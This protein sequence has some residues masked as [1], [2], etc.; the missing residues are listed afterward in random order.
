MH[1]L[2]IVF[3]II[4]IIK[5]TAKENNV[6]QVLSVTLEIGEVSTIVPSY[7]D[8]CWKWAVEREE[9][10][11]GCKLK[12]NM[13]KAVTICED[14]G[15]KFSTLEFKKICPKCGSEHTHLLKGDET[16]IKEIEVS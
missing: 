6:K 16:N 13:I 1:E 14:C 10:M 15:N 7:L 8:D 9:I 4:D 5:D 12:I 3:H 11:K 2:G